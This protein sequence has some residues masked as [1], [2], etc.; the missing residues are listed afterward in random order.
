MQICKRIKQTYSVWPIYFTEQ[1]WVILGILRTTDQ[2]LAKKLHFPRADIKN[3]DEPLPFWL[4]FLL[5]EHLLG[6]VCQ[7]AHVT[8]PSFFESH[9]S[10]EYS[11]L[12]S[13]VW[14]W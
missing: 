9:F 1:Y 5:I 3:Q 7:H 6:Q 13:A 10:V 11:A 4:S 14:T 8:R 12:F 2:A